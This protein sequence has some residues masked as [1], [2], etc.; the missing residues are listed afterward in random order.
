MKAENKELQKRIGK[1]GTQNVASFESFNAQNEEES[2]A[3]QSD[4]FE[5]IDYKAKYIEYKNK[6]KYLMN[7]LAGL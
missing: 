3:V 5:G 6:C 7:K 1:A 4:H 2:G